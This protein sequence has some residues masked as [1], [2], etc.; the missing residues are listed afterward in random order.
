M[1]FEKL[2][3]SKNYSGDLSGHIEFSNELG[4]IDLNLSPDFAQ[5]LV[6]AC[7]DEIVSV[8]RSA[9]EE[10]TV[11]V[12]EAVTPLEIPNKPSVKETSDE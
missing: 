3:I 1:T 10:M 2:W 5:R 12:L 8:S 6:A 7:A 9:A 11:K 4:K